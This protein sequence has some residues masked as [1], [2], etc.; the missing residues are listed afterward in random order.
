MSVTPIPIM[1]LPYGKI[2]LKEFKKY[3]FPGKTSFRG[4]NIVTSARA[5][6]TKTALKNRAGNKIG[7]HFDRGHLYARTSKCIATRTAIF[8]VFFFRRPINN[9]ASV[10]FSFLFEVIAPR[11]NINGVCA[12]TRRGRPMSVARAAGVNNSWLLRCGRTRPNGN[13][14]PPA[15]SPRRLLPVLFCFVLLFFPPPV[16]LFVFYPSPKTESERADGESIGKN[17]P[18]TAIRPSNSATSF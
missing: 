8:L 5:F 1:N 11:R 2:G 7:Q 17:R 6:D 10:F 16:I 15:P 12:R 13:L 9:N 18:R 14:S 3:P 4:G